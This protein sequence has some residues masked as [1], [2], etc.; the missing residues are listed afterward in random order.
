MTP[1]RWEEEAENWVRWARTPNHDDYW[2][3]SPA[4]FEEIVPAPQGLTLEI[5]CGEGRSTRDL[6]A[7]GHFVVATDISP[8]LIHYAAVADPAANYL[9]ADAAVL[10]F[11]DGSFDAIVAY[12]SLMNVEDLPR[13]VSESARVLRAGGRFCIC[14]THPIADAGRFE[15][16]DADAPFVIRGSYLAKRRFEETFERDG[17]RMTFHGWCYPLEAYFYA[18]EQAGFV[19]EKLREPGAPQAL[20]D[21]A[22]ERWRRLPNFLLIRAVKI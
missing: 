4:F 16:R 5:G 21:P 9:L 1:S 11:R 18:F 14:V 12:N 20:E 6:V 19:V 7:R 10:P 3:M 2:A 15:S 8:T 13:A 22:E 17:I